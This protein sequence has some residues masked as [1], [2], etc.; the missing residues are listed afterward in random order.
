[1]VE[2]AVGGLDVDV[3]VDG[4]R[5]VV[6]VVVVGGFGWRFGTMMEERFGLVGFEGSD[7]GPS[8]TL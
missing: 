7:L 3:V 1:M 5:V 2:R 8:S 6:V 4:V